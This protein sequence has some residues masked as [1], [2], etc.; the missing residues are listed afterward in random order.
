MAKDYT[1]YL[2]LKAGRKSGRLAKNQFVW[3]V[4]NDFV[5]SNGL[6]TYEELIKHFPNSIREGKYGHRGYAHPLIVTLQDAETDSKYI[7]R[8][9]DKKDKIIHLKND[10]GID[11]KYVVNKNWGVP[12]EGQYDCWQEF[13]DVA[14]SY[15]YVI[16]KFDNSLQIQPQIEKSVEKVMPSAN[17][18]KYPVKREGNTLNPKLVILL[19][20]PGGSATDE[21]SHP[22]YEMA[23][24]GLYKD[25]GM[26]ISDL[27]KYC[28]WWERLLSKIESDKLTE[29]DICCLEYYPYPSPDG[30]E[31]PQ[32][33]KWND[34]ALNANQENAELI[35][36]FVSNDIIVYGFYMAHGWNN[37]Q[38]IKSL[39]DSYK[40]Y[41]TISARTPASKINHLAKVLRDNNL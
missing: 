30:S 16:E 32:K 5:E 20:N 33:P 40:K 36:K 39:L 35:K 12:E 14:K 3:S 21:Q 34:Y 18:Y 8:F 28:P 26:K 29:N 11:E 23:K 9:Y 10:L 38:E 6:T 2:W 37:D 31:I 27:R 19:C 4:I 41:Y 17:E 22:E 13:L 7:G 24:V 1:K 25:S 15:G